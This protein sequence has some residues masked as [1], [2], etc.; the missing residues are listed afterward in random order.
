MSVRDLGPAP[1]VKNYKAFA[2]YC[3]KPAKK[4]SK[5][6][7]VDEGIDSEEIHRYSA[8]QVRAKPADYTEVAMGA[9]KATKATGKGL[10]SGSFGTCVGVVVTGK[11][12]KSSGFSSFLLHLSL[13][14][15][16]E[17]IR[18]E[19]KPFE[20]AVES[21]NLSSMKGYIYTVDTSLSAADV[22]GDA[23]MEQMATDLEEVYKSLQGALSLLVGGGRVTRSTHPFSRV[24]EMQVSPGGVVRTS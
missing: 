17:D 5:G 19:W 11:P 3:S 12:K 1:R 24:G 2:A 23:D 9:S 13:G 8:L 20:E 21:E 10:W 4:K 16:W 7:D 15:N 22:R 14:A 6:R 18:R